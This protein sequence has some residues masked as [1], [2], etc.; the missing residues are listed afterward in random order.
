MIKELLSDFYQLLQ[1]TY[2]PDAFKPYLSMMFTI[3]T[4]TIIFYSIQTFT[5]NIHD[6]AQ[7]PLTFR[8]EILQTKNCKIF[9]KTALNVLCR[10]ITTDEDTNYKP[11]ELLSFEQD[12]QSSVK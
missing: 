1:P 2:Q 11:Y 5:T 10:G 12:V 4:F 3:I 7:N 9:A 8:S 6:Y